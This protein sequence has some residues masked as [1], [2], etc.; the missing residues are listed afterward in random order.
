[1]KLGIRGKLFFLSLAMLA[2]AVL[3]LDAYVSSALR[4]SIEDRMADDLHVRCQLV[5][6]AAGGVPVA[7]APAKASALARTALVRVTLIDREGRVVGDSEVEPGQ[8]SGVENHRDRPE[9]REALAEGSGVA[10]R[11]SSTIHHPLLYVAERVDVPGPIA[12]VRLAVSLAP[13]EAAVGRARHLLAVGTAI[14]IVVAAA[15]SSLGAHL[16][17]RPLRELRDAAAAMTGDLAVRT[18]VRSDDEA[19]ALGTALDQLADNLSRSLE[20]LARERDRLGAVL[21]T[22]DDGVL[23]T[24]ADGTIVLANAAVRDLLGAR[25]V[26]DGRTPLEVARSAELAELLDDVARTRAAASREIETATP[27][28]RRLRV[29][30]TPLAGDGA[31]GV[32]AVLSDV[33]ELRRLETMRR[34]F[35]ANVSH[36][37]RTPI[38]AIRAAAETLEGGALADPD[39]AR[40]FVA[41]VARH[42]ARL[43][44]LVE[45]L[46]DLSRIEAQRLELRLEP[47]TAVAA[48]DHVVALN[49]LA[50]E[51]HR[52]VLRRGAC[53]ESALVRADRRALDQVLGNLIDNAV[54]YGGVGCAITLGASVVGDDVALSVA[55]TGPGIAPEHLPRLF[56][57]FYRVDRGRSR[58]VGGTG[59][60]LAIVKHLAEAMGGRVSVTSA[61]GTG[62]TF[63]VH[64]PSARLA[65][66]LEASDAQHAHKP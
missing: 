31:P 35:V 66:A 47:V 42:G 62:T 33:T 37:L 55:D 49:A 39:A 2:V 13:V 61:V 50:A 58:D 8:L 59:L 29:R 6:D 9:V 25:D 53:P 14:A 15:L 21:E 23:V 34:D 57:R 32:V 38:A 41:I 3:V 43:H 44:Q 10:H 24:A 65:P 52:V 27:V 56:E 5:R 54:K 40:D 17:T 11:A 19:G 28:A 26:L 60:G 1:M 4:A 7:D 30:A 51:R 12:V 45:D 20:R 64:L 48:L 46:L 63:I 16:V 36:E 18:R 22:M